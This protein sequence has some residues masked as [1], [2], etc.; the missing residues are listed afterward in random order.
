MNRI[1]STLIVIA[2]AMMIV[3]CKG[4]KDM[5]VSVTI[6]PSSLALVEE[7]SRQLVAKVLPE[8]AEER[9]I[10][11]SSSDPTVASVSETGVVVGIKEGPATITASCGGK[12]GTCAV[13]V[14][15]S[16]IVNL[17]LPSGLKWASC[18]LGASKPEEYGNYYAW[19]EVITYYADGHNQDNPCNTWRS[20]TSPPITGYNWTS[21]RWCNGTEF[22]LTK[23]CTKSSYGN[24]DDIVVLQRGE[25]TGETVDDV[26]RA[27]LGDKWHM[28]TEANFAEL[29]DFTDNSWTTYNG[30]SGWKFTSKTNS[31]N[32]IFLPAAGERHN[33]GIYDAGSVGYY[34]SSS[35]NPG[36]PSRAYTQAFSQDANQMRSYD[37]HYGLSVRP[38]TQ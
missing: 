13:T 5:I 37:R 19:G 7:E 3:S 35:L 12:S 1:I 28:P 4:K 20:R 18:N 26:A 14:F 22:T 32:W 11:W 10:A 16:G 25:K 24:V 8:T 29:V 6:T 23:Y 2:V 31:A 30:V 9:T 36:F 27:R 38:V 21:Y 33:T 15:G 34:W 17:D